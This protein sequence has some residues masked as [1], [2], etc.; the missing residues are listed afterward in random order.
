MII[1]MLGKLIPKKIIYLI[2][3]LRF[4]SEEKGKNCKKCKT[5]LNFLEKKHKC[6]SC[7]RMFCSN[8]FKWEILVPE[9]A[10]R[11]LSK[12]CEKC[13]SFRKD[14]NLMSLYDNYSY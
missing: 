4:I 7:C 10:L 12:V 6:S 11:K 14:K 13:Y 5:S 1:F 2:N 9:R 3:F 8:C